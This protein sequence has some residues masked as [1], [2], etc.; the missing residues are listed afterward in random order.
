MLPRTLPHSLPSTLHG[1]AHLG[2]VQAPKG[3]LQGSPPSRCPAC[4]THRPRGAPARPSSL[5]PEARPQDASP[6]RPLP[7]SESEAVLSQSTSLI[8]GQ[9]QLHPSPP[10]S[11]RPRLNVPDSR[12]HVTFCDMPVPSLPVATARPS[13]SGG[14]QMCAGPVRQLTNRV[15]PGSRAARQRP[16]LPH[17]QPVRSISRRGN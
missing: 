10:P 8:Q 14:Q 17:Q 2:C 7:S 15:L 5:C 1:A 4:V 3:G 12:H 6:T 11:P 13:G 9:T 16:S